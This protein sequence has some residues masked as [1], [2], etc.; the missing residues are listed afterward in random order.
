MTK[1]IKIRTLEV[2]QDVSIANCSELG[3]I[4]KRVKNGLYTVLY[5]GHE[6][7]MPRTNLAVFVHG[8][9]KFGPYN[10]SGVSQ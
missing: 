4:V 8:F 6:I 3:K 1:I 7:D 5:Q 2:G 10:A 9:W